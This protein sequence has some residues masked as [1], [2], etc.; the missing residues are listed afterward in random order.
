MSTAVGADRGRVWRALTV[1]RE[2][3]GWDERLLALLDPADHYPSEGQQLRWRYRLGSVAIVLRYSMLEVTP[4][5]RMRA[6]SALGLFRFDETFTLSSETEVPE[7]TR[8]HLKLIAE[9]SVPVVGGFLDRFAVRLM[10]TELVDRKLRSVQ[11][12]CENH[13]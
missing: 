6:T 5:E 8:L 11:R 10:A 2:L 1:P 12:W 7:R 9:N 3:I 13:P 4:G